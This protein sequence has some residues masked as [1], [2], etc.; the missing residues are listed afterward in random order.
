MCYPTGTL[1][2]SSGADVAMAMDVLRLIEDS[3]VPAPCPIEQ[4]WTAAS[5]SF[6]SPAYSP[7]PLLFSW[8]GIIM[9]LPPDDAPTRTAITDAFFTYKVSP[10]RAA[11]GGKEE[12][13]M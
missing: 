6:M 8:L 9:Y 1:S 3:Q 4:R 2:S 12:C 5:S 10:R 11:P 13:W 7:S